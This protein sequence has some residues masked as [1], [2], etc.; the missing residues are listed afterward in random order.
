MNDER[1]R[2]GQTGI[3]PAAVKREDSTVNVGGPIRRYDGRT[4]RKTDRDRQFNPRVSSVWMDR[5]G[6][7]KEAEEERVGDKITQAYF[8][9]LLLSLY[10]RAQG[11]ELRPFGLS[12]PAFEAAQAIADHM[13]WSLSAVLEDAIAA[14][15]KQ[16]HF[17]NE[18]EVKRS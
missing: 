18:A 14:R 4:T 5:F 15:Y 8:L 3:L 16:F 13:D 1:G 9:D 6:A 7:A 12:E 10:E 11:S 17:A 2:P